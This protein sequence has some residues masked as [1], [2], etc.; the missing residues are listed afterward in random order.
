[1]AVWSEVN[2]SDLP[3]DL[4]FDAEY[5]DPKLLK[6]IQ[7]IKRTSHAPLSDLA[8]ILDGN[9]AAIS[10]QFC[11]QGIRYLRGQDLSDFFISDHSPLYIPE[12]QYVRIP[13]CHMKEGDVLVGIVGTIGS[14]GFVTDRFGKL[15]GSCKLAIVRGRKVA[16]EFLAAFLASS[17]GQDEIRRRIRGSVQTGLILPD[18]KT[19]PV[20]ILSQEEC[21]PVTDVIRKAHRKRTESV[22]LYQEAESLLLSDL[23]LSHFHEAAELFYESVYSETAEAGRIDAEHFQPKFRRV[24][25]A[26]VQYKNGHNLLGNLLQAVTNGVE[27][28]T[29]LKEGTP[30][31]RVGDMSRLRISSASAQKIDNILA[32]KLRPKIQIR[33]G[34]ILTARSGSIGQ[35][36]VVT[37]HDYESILSS[38]LMRLRLHTNAPIKSIYLAL[39]LATTPGVMQILKHSNGAVVPEIAQPSLLKIV[40]PTPAGDF[41]DRL[42]DLICRSQKAEDESGHLL[43][44]A[45]RMVEGLILKN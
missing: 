23:G 35:A 11:E 28:R 22:S 32:T 44:Q 39:F 1:M 31:I 41:Q 27:C 16:P 42:G 3:T 33:P 45:K 21:I 20:P 6:R 13:R 29:F 2:F 8:D 30:Y 14:V 12:D 5:H 10:E 19:I 15:T 37:E 26:C 34:D 7:A 40:V 4:R 18:L 43:N 25:E 36:A 9:H 17:V 38:H 24:I